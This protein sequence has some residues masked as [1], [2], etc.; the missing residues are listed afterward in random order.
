M[1]IVIWKKNNFI[2]PPKI[3]LNLY[4]PD[5]QIS[6]VKA[7]RNFIS[8]RKDDPFD[9]VCEAPNLDIKGCLFLAPSGNTYIL[10]PGAT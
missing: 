6:N 9:L 5:Y 7:N 4:F 3:Q 10:W 8:V 1:N 2:I